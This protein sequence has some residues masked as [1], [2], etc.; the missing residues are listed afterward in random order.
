MNIIHIM[1]EYKNGNLDIL[2]KLKNAIW[3][4]KCKYAYKEIYGNN[5]IEFSVLKTY[6]D[7]EN[8][9]DYLKQAINKLYGY[10]FD[11]NVYR[12]KFFYKTFIYSLDVEEEDYVDNFKKVEL[13]KEDY[14]DMINSWLDEIFNNYERQ[15]IKVSEENA[16]VKYIYKTLAGKIKNHVR[17]KQGIY[18]RQLKDG[19]S[20]YIDNSTT[21]DDYSVYSLMFSDV[22]DDY[23]DKVIAL[24]ERS[25][26]YCFTKNQLTF[27]ENLQDIIRQYSNGELFHF[28]E[29][30]LPKLNR[31]FIGSKMGKDGSTITRNLKNMF[32]RVK[33]RLDGYLAFTEKQRQNIQ[34]MK[35]KQ[36]I[37]SFKSMFVN[38]LLEQG[39][40]KKDIYN[41]NKLKDKHLDALKKLKFVQISYKGY[42]D[43]LDYIPVNLSE[44]Q[45]KQC[46]G[47]FNYKYTETYYYD[48]KHNMYKEINGVWYI[49]RTVIDFRKDIRDLIEKGVEKVA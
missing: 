29:R 24:A 16:I 6:D 31:R 22:K 44:P 4:S 14:K 43:K 37:L 5:I 7:I 2:E 49:K 18:R 35:R 12:A 10:Y 32:N 3:N 15:D 28:T 8:V 48:D 19:T 26:D 47:Y 41:F 46:T 45:Q 13:S 17:E 33:T 34:R 25:P 38:P 9:E 1:N 40:P 30:G 20:L 23:K 36:D 27:I 42:W 39:V 11:N 21:K